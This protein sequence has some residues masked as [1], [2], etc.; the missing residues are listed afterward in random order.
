MSILPLKYNICVFKAIISQPP[1]WK[2]SSI[3]FDSQIKLL[4]SGCM[5][6]CVHIVFNKI[7]RQKLRKDRNGL[8]LII[9]IYLCVS[10]ASCKKI[11]VLI[12]AFSIMKLSYSAESVHEIP[13]DLETIAII[14]F[15]QLGTDFCCWKTIRISPSE[16]Q[17]RWGTSEFIIV[18]CCHNKIC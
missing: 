6:V 4:L 17:Q 7:L 9:K 18:F 1:F 10:V 13:I 16:Q 2:H 5:C 14:V 8:M 12:F 11:V 15:L 3:M